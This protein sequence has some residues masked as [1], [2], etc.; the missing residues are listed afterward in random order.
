MGAICLCYFIIAI[1]VTVG[2][3]NEQNWRLETSSQCNR[4]TAFTLIIGCLFCGVVWP[5][6]VIIKLIVFFTTIMK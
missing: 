1:A 2:I 4:L 6:T 5:I 3:F